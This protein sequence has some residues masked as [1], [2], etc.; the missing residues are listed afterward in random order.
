VAYDFVRVKGR[1]GKISSSA[2]GAVTVADCLEIYEPEMLRWVFTSVRPGTEFQISFDLDVIKLYE[3]YDRLRRLAHSPD[4]G[5]KGD[6]KRQTARR[7]LELASIDRRRIEAGDPLPFVPPF[8]GIAMVLQAFDGDLERS[9]DYYQSRGEIRGDEERRLFAQRARCA[10]NWVGRYAPDD[11]R[12]R[13]RRQPV[14]TGLEGDPRRLIG[15][16]VEILEENPE[17]DEAGLV[18]HLKTIC[19][20][21]SLTPATFFPYAY[22]LLIG[23][24]K[25]PK[26]TTLIGTMGVARALP[27]LK[28]GL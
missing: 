17:I 11:F 22:D 14:T 18:P 25:G 13:I 1:G 23:R 2:G 26:L 9:L 12:F 10:W 24:P 4:D 7:T 15:R 16:L 21:T 5:G 3:D 27:L 28:A 19:D 8:R 20:G 6:R